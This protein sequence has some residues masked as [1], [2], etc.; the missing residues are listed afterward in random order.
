[1]FRRGRAQGSVAVVRECGA[2][3]GT[4]QFRLAFAAI[5]A[6]ECIG[7]SR[8]PLRLEAG[9]ALVVDEAGVGDGSSFAIR[10]LG[11]GAVALVVSVDCR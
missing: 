4:A 8:S 5:G 3:F 1:M 6:Q 9:H 11:A 10:P 7:A 2:E